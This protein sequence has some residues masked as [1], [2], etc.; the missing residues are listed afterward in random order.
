LVA[1]VAGGR[2]VIGVLPPTGLADHSRLFEALELAFAVRFVGGHA[3]DKALDGVLSLGPDVDPLSDDGRLLRAATLTLTGPAGRTAGVCDVH[4]ARQGVDRRVRNIVL[5]GQAAGPSL[6][7]VDEEPLA[8]GPDG[9]VWLRRTGP[10]PVFRVSACLPTLEEG[11]TLLAALHGP[12]SLAVVALIE[13]IRALG[14]DGV[15]RPGL[16]AAFVFDDP[17]LRLG[18]YGYINYRTLL[19]HADAHGYHAVMAMIPLD[20]RCRSQETVAMFRARPDR[21]SLVVHGNNHSPH[22]LMTTRDFR[23]ALSLCAQSLQR[24][25]RFEAQTSLRVDRVMMP[26]HGAWSQITARALGALGYDALCTTQHRPPTETGPEPS[27]LAGLTPATFVD[28]CAVVPRLPLT[29]DRTGI[30]LRAFLGHPLVL[31][32]HHDDLASGLEPLAAA[33]AFVNDMGDVQWASVGEVVQSNY[34]LCVD[35]GTAVVRP[36]AGRV[37]VAIPDGVERLTVRGPRDGGGRA[38]LAGWADPGGAPRKFG[39]VVGVSS[40]DVTIRLQSAWRTDAATISS[41]G[42]PLTAL[43]RRRLTEA[44]DQFAPV[45]GM[46]LLA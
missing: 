20:A 38:G 45:H 29:L 31:Y 46:H 4:I 16:R 39:D 17:N 35:D 12:H 6:A 26:P 9:P 34:D 40:G 28:G 13:F 24:I 5:G 36:W 41:P 33:T 19:D 25:A 14:S 18:R 22:E 23:A 8:L 7:P 3:G 43:L 21:L 2:R 27:A 11:Q 30:A 1:V 15:S 42:R 10:Q 32:G 44:R 37:R